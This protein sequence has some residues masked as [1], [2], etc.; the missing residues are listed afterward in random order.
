MLCHGAGGEDR[1]GVRCG[2]EG[3]LLAGVPGDCDNRCC[4]HRLVHFWGGPSAGMCSV[5]PV[6]RQQPPL[7]LCAPK[8]IMGGMRGSRWSSLPRSSPHLHGDTAAVRGGQGRQ[9][10]H[11]DLHGVWEPQAHRHLAERGGPFGCQQQV[12]GRWVDGGAPGG[13]IDGTTVVAALPCL[14]PDVLSQHFLPK[15]PFSTPLHLC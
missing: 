15:C 13:S 4:P 2:V 5:T 8:A 12:P 11:P 1:A 3:T 9:Q 7:C 6:C 14:E 10:C